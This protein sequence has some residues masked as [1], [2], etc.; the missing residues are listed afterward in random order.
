MTENT[1]I[2]QGCTNHLGYIRQNGGELEHGEDS[3]KPGYTTLGNFGDGDGGEVLGFGTFEE[4]ARSGVSPWDS[5]PYHLALILKPDATQYGAAEDKDHTCMRPNYNWS[6]GPAQFY[7]YP[8]D[9]RTRMLPVEQVAEVGGGPPG[10]V[11]A[12][13]LDTSEGKFGSGYIVP[14]KPLQ[15]GATFHVAAT[16]D[17]A[18]G[19]HQQAFSFQTRWAPND[20]ELG[21]DPGSDFGRVVFLADG[22][23]DNARAWYYDHK[24]RRHALTLRWDPNGGHSNGMPIASREVKVGRGNFRWCFQ[25]GGGTSAYKFVRRCDSV[26]V[27]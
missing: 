12:T 21:S 1:L 22:A 18:D 4:W 25:S 14:L 8:A 23:F 2:D 13:R 27:V 6:A 20:V 16:W 7:S 26:Y 3:S 24:E 9:G 17:C 15:G 5:A 10:G 19:A 11:V